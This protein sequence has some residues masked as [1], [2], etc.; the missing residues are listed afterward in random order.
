MLALSKIDEKVHRF[1]CNSKRPFV[2]TTDIAATLG[3]AE[4]II[5]DSLRTLV[6][7]GL[8]SRRQ[9][10]RGKI[11]WALIQNEQGFNGESGVRRQATF[12]SYERIIDLL[13]VLILVALTATTLFIVLSVTFE[14][15]LKKNAEI[16][17]VFENRA[18]NK[19]NSMDRQI[20]Q[21]SILVDSLQRVI[22]EI[23]ASYSQPQTA[24]PVSK[25]VVVPKS[26]K[27]PV[28]R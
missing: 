14:N 27:K 21:Q 6:N 4:E 25:P 22:D 24:P 19:I 28:H 18:V 12:F 5:A 10:D 23:R 2:E 11:I 8:V 9:D 17:A 3:I 15:K 7:A 20:R 13:F 26:K 1:L 16:N